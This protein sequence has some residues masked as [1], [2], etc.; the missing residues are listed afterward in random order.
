MAEL[1]KWLLWGIGFLGL[2]IS[3]VSAILILKG[4]PTD[5]DIWVN[6]RSGTWA[7]LVTVSV[8]S[9]PQKVKDDLS[10]RTD[11]TKWGFGLLITGF[12]MQALGAIGSM[13]TK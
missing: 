9:A 1:V 2:I 12:V 7:E 13:P 5:K 3:V 10:R 4:T 6:S 8:S 11:L